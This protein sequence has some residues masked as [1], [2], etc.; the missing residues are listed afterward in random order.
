MSQMERIGV[1][2]RSYNRIEDA[3]IQVKYLWKHFKAY[4][5]YVVVVTNGDAQGH[6]YPAGQGED[7]VLRLDKGNPGHL[8][9]DN[10]MFKASIE[11]LHAQGIRYALCLTSDTWLLNE[12]LLKKYLPRLIA[13]RHQ[14]ISA[15]WDTPPEVALDLMLVDV[16]FVLEHQLFWADWSPEILIY[17]R[18][19]ALVSPEY[20][21][22]YGRIREIFPIQY[23]RHLWRPG[24]DPSG[25][26]HALG[27]PFY[28]P[29]AAVVTHHAELL[30]DGMTS[31]KRYANECVGRELFPDVGYEARQLKEM[32][33]RRW[34]RRCYHAIDDVLFP[35][36]RPFYTHPPSPSLS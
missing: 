34:Y 7:A 1:A 20:P 22:P 25:S 27:R 14:W 30:P 3:V 9:G 13:G 4:P 33:L 6:V 8:C 36:Y 16:K 23:P 19:E 17:Q 12:Q 35:L 21:R 10:D 5:Y 24:F 2:L 26:Y 29:R 15:Q 11:H 18:L 32:R 31:K 28:F